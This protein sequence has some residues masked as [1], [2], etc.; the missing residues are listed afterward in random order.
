MFMCKLYLNEAE[1]QREVEVI[2]YWMN[3]GI[4]LNYYHLLKQ[5]LFV[6][7]FDLLYL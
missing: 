1:R 2:Q 5:F 4:H 3:G 7:P 6:A